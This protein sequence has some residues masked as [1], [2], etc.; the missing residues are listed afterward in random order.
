MRDDVNF[1]LFESTQ[2]SKEEIICF[3]HEILLKSDNADFYCQLI[4]I[5]IFGAKIYILQLH[6]ITLSTEDSIFF[7]KNPDHVL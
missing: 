4:V 6:Y 1:F 5:Q 3:E 7:V 2:P